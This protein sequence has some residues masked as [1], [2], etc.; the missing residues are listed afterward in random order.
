MAYSN[1]S[2][3]YT[4]KILP[5]QFFIPPHFLV[6]ENV[7][8]Q[9]FSIFSPNVQFSIHAS[10][11]KHYQTECTSCTFTKSSR[12]CTRS[13]QNLPSWPSISAT[14]ARSVAPSQ[15]SSSST[16]L[17]SWITRNSTRVAPFCHCL[18]FST[19]FVFVRVG[20]HLVGPTKT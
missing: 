16:M 5:F 11:R 17:R 7:P 13:F 3:E 19:S 1:S 6:S 9:I 15:R 10:P 20:S 14:A 4:V 18:L 8:P 12:S 2:T